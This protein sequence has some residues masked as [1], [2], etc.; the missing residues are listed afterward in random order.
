MIQDKRQIRIKAPSHAIFDLIDRM[1][2][3]FPIYSFLE[4]KPFFFIRILLVDGLSAA[5]EAA[6]LIRPD[7]VLK[8]SVGDT[9]GPFT[10]TEFERP[11]KYWFSLKSLFFDCQTGYSLHFK[12]SVTEL[13]FD[14]IAENP[15]FKERIWWFIFKPFHGLLANKV[16]NVIKEKIE[17]NTYKAPPC[18]EKKRT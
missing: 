17:P 14:L 18:Q 2:N 6:R 11:T 1:P 12:D 10:L 5:W 15:T 7:V 16:L 4:A 13:S 8:L 9:M 3:K